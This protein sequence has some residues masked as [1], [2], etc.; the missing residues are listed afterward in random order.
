MNRRPTGTGGC[1][2]G[3]VGVED[4]FRLLWLRPVFSGSGLLF[5]PN[6]ARLFGELG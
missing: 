3:Q 1:V 6:I 4:L 5:R 2:L